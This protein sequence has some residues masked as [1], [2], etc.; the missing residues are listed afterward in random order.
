LVVDDSESLRTMVKSYLAQEGFRVVTAEIKI[1]YDDPQSVGRNFA[2][3]D[4][5][6][7]FA[8]EDA[9]SS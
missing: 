5:E 9:Y 4:V 2:W 8:S 7:P 3:L 6:L 1:Y